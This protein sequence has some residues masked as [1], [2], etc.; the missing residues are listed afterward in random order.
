MRGCPSR[1]VQRRLQP[2]AALRAL[3]RDDE[4]EWGGWAPPG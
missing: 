4:L 2:D 1:L 3:V